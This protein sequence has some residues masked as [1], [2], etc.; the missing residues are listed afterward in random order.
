MTH[1]FLAKSGAWA[2]E[3]LLLFAAYIPHILGALGLLSVLFFFFA[4]LYIV[5]LGRVLKKLH[6]ISAKTSRDA[7]KDIFPTQ[8]LR[9]LWKEYD[10]T[11]HAQYEEQDGQR[12]LSAIRSTIP[13]EMFFNN[14]Y[15]VDSYLGTEFFKHLPGIFTGLGIVGTFGGIIEGLAQFQVTENAETVRQSL[16][17]LMHSVG[18]AFLLS[19]SAIALAMVYTVFE[20]LIL[21]SLYRKTEAISHVIDSHFESGA[22]EE[23][24][25]RLVDA[26]E[27][28]ASQAKILKDSLV[29]DLKQV[30]QELTQ[31]QIEAGRALH[32]QQLAA[33][34]EGNQSLGEVISTSIEKSLKAPLDEIAASVKSASGEQS[35][36][37][38]DMLNDVMVHFSQRLN[39]LFGGQINNIN[40]LN[41]Q[42]A[43]SM[44]DAVASLN[45]LLGNLEN[46]GK[47]STDEMATKMAAAIQSMEERQASINAQTQ[48]F[49]DQIRELVESSQTETQHKLQSTL[50]TIGEQMI[51]ILGTLN[52]SQ[53]QAFANNKAREQEMA[54]RASSAVSQ[55]TSSIEAAIQEISTATKTMSQ[56]VAVL[57]SATTSSVDKMNIGA[58]R[59]G[60]AASSF[61]SAGEQ[62]TGT[63]SQI[64]ETSNKLAETSGSLTASSSA[65]QEALRDYRTQRETLANLL[66]EVRETIELARKE[67]SITADV[68]QRIDV[69]TAKLATAQKAADEYLDGVNE[70]LERSSD[71]FREAVVSTLAKVNHEFHEKLSSAVG[72]LG[73]AIQE[74]ESSLGTIAAPDRR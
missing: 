63:L 1:E 30:L 25:S 20:K 57:S 10:E 48:E 8:H 26:S 66:S 16:E 22:G 58:E 62:V 19:G 32:A 72:L 27:A 65:L 55:M 17:S 40:E 54:D 49:V 61:A 70:V 6:I 56:S 28:S 24:L 12:R 45:T 39:D 67:A 73:T 51:S 18:H 37:A 31:S 14:Q 69:S 13:A 21:A 34:K 7:I 4:L 68:L 42:T 29:N 50:E 60:T 38:I 23:Y 44:Q 46:S 64:T 47:R 33:T 52:T 41:K 36:A 53:A 9:H 2:I 3:G 71:S 5:R 74:L 15:V 11:L 59:L 35:K 43:Q